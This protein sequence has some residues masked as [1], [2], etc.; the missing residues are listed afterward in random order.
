[1]GISNKI[2]TKMRTAAKTEVVPLPRPYTDDGAVVAAAVI[3]AAASTIAQLKLTSSTARGKDI[4]G[5]RQARSTYTSTISVT[6]RGQQTWLVS[7]GVQTVS[8]WAFDWQVKI[9]LEDGQAGVSANITTPTT[10]TLDGTLVNKSAHGELRDLVLTGLRAGRLPGGSAEVAVSMA[11]LA[12]RPLEPAFVPAAERCLR[13]R[14]RA[15]E[16]LTALA[17]VPFPLEGRGPGGLRWRLGE[18]GA[19]AGYLAAADI[20]T[21][22]EARAISLRCPALPS[23]DA[24]ADALVA[25]RA[26][27]LFSAV[28]RAMRRLDPDLERTTRPAEQPAADERWST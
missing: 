5:I 25:L 3:R 12:S 1:M 11:G 6:Q 21:G 4:L 15:E 9:V 8:S 17:L 27:A 2:A 16:I 10:L 7:L 22:G 24:M 20:T 19:L 13:T 14:L 28:E 26:N 23:G 18:S